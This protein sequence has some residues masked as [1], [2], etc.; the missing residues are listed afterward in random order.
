[1]IQILISSK[2]LFGISLSQ[3]PH[4]FNGS[5]T[6]SLLHLT[7]FMLVFQLLTSSHVPAMT[8]TSTHAPR[9]TPF[10]QFLTLSMVST[11]C[12]RLTLYGLLIKAKLKLSLHVTQTNDAVKVQLHVF[13]NSVL[14][15]GRRS[16]SHDGQWVRTN[17]AGS[18]W[19]EIRF[20]PWVIREA[21]TLI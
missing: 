17:S 5:L 14:N 4:K 3:E 10:M 16:S 21:I 7:V 11:P 13:L 2:Y 15:E 18:H 9:S 8:R 20:G 12:M 6:A 1:V 19:T